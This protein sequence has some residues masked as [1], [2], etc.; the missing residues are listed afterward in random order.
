MIWRY[1]QQ[2]W[3]CQLIIFLLNRAPSSTQ[4]HP[5]PPNSFQPPR[6]SL[7]HPQR[8]KNQNIARNWGISPNLG[9]KFQSCPFCLKIGTHAILEVLIPTPDFEFR[10]SDPKILFRENLGWKS[11]SCPFC[12]KTGKHDILEELIL[13]PNLEFRTSDPKILFWANLGWKS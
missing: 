1:D 2:L 8:Y 11:Q 6:S 10:N 5:P 7:Q 12:L 3:Q 9:R 13:I 4:L